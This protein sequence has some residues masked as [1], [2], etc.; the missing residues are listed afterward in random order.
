MALYEKLNIPSY[1]NK[2]VIVTL[3]DGT[4]SQG[5]MGDIANEDWEDDG[6]QEAVFIESEARI[7]IDEIIL[8]EIKSIEVVETG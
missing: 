3:N 1:W 6:E 7:V 8:N 4:T 5:I 2:M